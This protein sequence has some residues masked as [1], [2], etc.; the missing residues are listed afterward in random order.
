MV[1]VVPSVEVAAGGDS[2]GIIMQGDG[3]T[4]V[5]SSPVIDLDNNEVYPA[6][7]AGIKHG[8]VIL[9]INDEKVESDA[10][11]AEKIDSLGLSGQ[12]AQLTIKRDEEML[13]INV[14]PVYCMDSQKFRI[15]VFLKDKTMGI[16]TLTFVEPK[17]GK[18][19]ALGHQIMPF[20]GKERAA[21][22]HGS[23]V[24]A[25]VNGV[26]QG[27]SGR[28]GEKV[29]SFA[30][31]KDIL[32]NIEKNSPLG[33]YGHMEAVEKREIFPAASRSQ[34]EVG[35]AQLLTVVDGHKIERFAVEI[36]KVSRQSSPEGKGFVIK[37]IDERLLAKTGG[38]VQ[39]MSGS[40]I[41]QNGRIVGA[42]T[43]VFLDDSTRGYGCFLEWMLEENHILP[44][45]KEKN[46]PFLFG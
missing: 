29:G 16:G 43:H 40:P 46:L 39:G 30:Q 11:A 33:I 36:E 28:P 22:W 5:G 13:T 14:K 15:G 19:G 24:R 1:D 4:V 10:A 6:K 26:R 38:I 3:A 41:I 35:C 20:Y 18:Y 17:S 44:I 31:G 21:K 7:E 32:G 9:A 8:D 23:I 34:L 42:L 12:M 27:Q 45:N 37:V 25:S 2:I